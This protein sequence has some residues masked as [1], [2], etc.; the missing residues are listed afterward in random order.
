MFFIIPIPRFRRGETR[1]SITAT[2]VLCGIIGLFLGFYGL[3]QIGYGAECDGKEMSPGQQCLH[4]G[5]RA[6]TYE[7]EQAKAERSGGIIAVTG[8]VLGVGCLIG[9]AIRASG[10]EKPRR[11]VAAR[12]PGSP[13]Q[14]SGY[15]HQVARY[16]AGRPP[17]PPPPGYAPPGY[18]PPGY[19]PP[20]YAPPP[21]HATPV[22]PVAA[23]GTDPWAPQAGP[24]ELSA[25]RPPPAA[26]AE[27]T[28]D[29]DPPPGRA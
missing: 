12:P 10:F 17:A 25:L 16:A 8:F 11:A 22:P 24:T 29:L 23:P 18:A 1:S 7:E 21:A 4:V 9:A 6:Y 20:G 15:G 27:L 19:A 26:S 14:V 3:Y 28:H 5:D 13:M 2:L